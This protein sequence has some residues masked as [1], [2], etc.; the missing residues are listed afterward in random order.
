MAN[1]SIPMN[2]VKQILILYH[3]SVPIKQIARQLGMSKNTVKAY[4]KRFQ[5]SGVCTDDLVE[6]SSPELQAKL[7]VPSLNEQQRYEAF[8]EQAPRYLNDLKSQRH[9]TKLLLWEEEF[10][11]GRTG[12]RYSQFCHHL[13]QFER[14]KSGSMVINHVPGDKMFMDF[15]GDKLS[16]TDENSGK[17]TPCDLLIL[18]LGYSNYTRVVA[19][20]S[21]SIEDVVEGL[22]H[23]FNEL[24]GVCKALVPDNFKAAVVKPNR[25]EPRI[26]ERFLD[27]ANYYGFAVIPARVAK[28]KD[29]SKVETAVKNVYQQIY[30]RIRNQSYGSLH[31]LNQALK[32]H[33]DAFNSRVMKDYSASRRELFEREEKMLLSPLP[34]ERYELI[35]QHSLK[36]Q[37][38]NHVFLRAQHKYF[39]VPYQ[40]IGQQV[41]VLYSSKLVRI[42]H[43]GECIA[44]HRG[45]Y[46]RYTTHTDHMGST[47]REYLNSINPDI[48]KQRGYAIDQSVGQVI[49]HILE[50]P[51]H[52][53]Q[54]YKS[55]QGIFSLERKVSRSK[56]IEACQIALQANIIGYG[57][58]Q[59]I[60]ATPYSSLKPEIVPSGSLPIHENVRG[61]YH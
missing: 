46:P 21:Q 52:P 48:L 40:F 17:L 56:F 47:H 14:N 30:A 7:V 29:K 39:S 24:D 34:M 58:I 26:N 50:R 8:L 22:V 44:T 9:L 1:Q 23:C 36:V 27:M 54:N 5:E 43:K 41:T 18:T 51:K 60:C 10:A 28:P 20:P 11:A 32:E 53:E 38:N 42:Y 57:Y 31:S 6:L 35:S 61:N 4:L 16:Y 59:R 19:I 13:L 25:Y 55:C 12:Y 33:C 45:P 2:E 3:Q 49:E 37:S 15:A